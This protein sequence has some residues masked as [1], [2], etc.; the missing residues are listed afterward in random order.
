MKGQIF[1]INR[2]G[3]RLVSAKQL[4]ELYGISVKTIFGWTYRKMIPFK[5]IG[6]RIIRFDLDE[7][8]R[9]ASQNTENPNRGN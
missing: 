4:A 9:W 5:R 8:E 7:I 2:E 3:K 6:P 1:D